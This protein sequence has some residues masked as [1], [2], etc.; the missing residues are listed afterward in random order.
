VQIALNRMD[1]NEDFTVTERR[2]AKALLC[3]LSRLDRTK[4]PMSLLTGHKVEDLI[5]RE[6]PEGKFTLQG[7]ACK[8]LTSPAPIRA[9]PLN[10]SAIAAKSLSPQG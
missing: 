4:V 9:F 2:E 5:N 10:S 7:F 3:A 6:C 8:Q 1:S